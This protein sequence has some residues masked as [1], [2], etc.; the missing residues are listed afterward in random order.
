[1]KKKILII[2][3][4]LYLSGTEKQLLNILKVIN[5]TFEFK[6]FFL[7]YDRILIKDFE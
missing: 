2:I 6:I 5:K 7:D 1:M 3:K 4:S